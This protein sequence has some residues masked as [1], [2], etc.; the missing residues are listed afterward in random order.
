MCRCFYIFL[1]WECIFRLP[2]F[3]HCYAFVRKYILTCVFLNE[4][5]SA[6]IL[7]GIIFRAQKQQQRQFICPNLMLFFAYAYGP[8]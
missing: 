7:V 4:S 3:C 2:C 5:K 6:L 1:F 8:Q